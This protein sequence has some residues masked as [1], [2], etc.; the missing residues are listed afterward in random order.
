MSSRRGFLTRLA[1]T[2]VAGALVGCRNEAAVGSAYAAKPDDY[3]AIVGLS[4]IGTIDLSGY[5]HADFPYKQTPGDGKV[6]VR[7]V[8]SGAGL[9]DAKGNIWRIN[10][11]H[12]YLTPEMFGAK[13]DLT[14]DDSAAIQAALDFIESSGQPTYL[15][16]MGR[17]L[18][19]KT[20]EGRQH[21]SI[22][23]PGLFQLADAVDAPIIDI[24]AAYNGRK[25]SDVVYDGFRLE[26]NKDYQTTY[27]NRLGACFSLR[28][29]VINP[30]TNSDPNGSGELENVVV[31]N[32]T[33][34]NGKV[35]SFYFGKTTF[36]TRGYHW[37]GLKGKGSVNGIFLDDYCEYVTLSGVVMQQHQ[38][39]IRDNGSSNCSFVGGTICNNSEAGIYIERTGRNTSKKIF[40][41]MHI[42]HNKRGVWIGWEVGTVGVPIDHVSVVNCQILA[43]D[44]QGVIGS[45]GH[46]VE[47]VGNFFGGNG[48]AGTNTVDD[49]YISSSCKR[50][51]VDNKHINSTGET[52]HAVYWENPRPTGADSHAYH[53][54]DGTF[55]GYTTPLDYAPYGDPTSTPLN[56]NTSVVQG[57]FEYWNA[58]NNPPSATAS[59]TNASV[60]LD[61]IPL[62]TICINNADSTGAERWMA[63]KG[64]SSGGANLL[65]TFHRL[66]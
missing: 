21:A 56:A 51:R 37:H 58:L 23:G 7:K 26:G 49:I 11:V 38:Y 35:S 6:T 52:R 5:D 55:Q 31:S 24:Y 20:I 18:V 34:N 65:P 48:G 29:D 2:A 60:H 19:G 10:S 3:T 13:G 25:I 1:G 43:N 66:S 40:S 36:V 39:G 16:V 50:W 27:D 61:K 32:I 14:V 9:T 54:I 45:G 47:I 53:R 15:C 63:V 64:T 28:C 30:F 33:A 44:Y 4:E 57:V 59:N 17:Y 62:G 22:V 46:D 8:A 42:N 41:G 12:G